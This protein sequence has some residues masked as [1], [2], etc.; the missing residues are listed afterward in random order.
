MVK[1]YQL[2]SAVIVCSFMVCS[3]FL[4]SCATLFGDKNRTVTVSTNPAGARVYLNGAPVGKSPAQVVI[5]STLS[6][7]VI[8]VKAKGYDTITY[9]ITTSIQPVAFLNILNLVCWGIDFATGNV[10]RLDTNYISLDLDRKSAMLIGPEQKVAID[11]N[12][13]HACQI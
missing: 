12:K 1:G 6:S 13:P 3:L 10:M 8:T 4:S 7:N 9:P 5:A 2:K 11:L